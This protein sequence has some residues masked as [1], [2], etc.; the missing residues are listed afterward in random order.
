[1]RLLLTYSVWSMELIL[2]RFWLDFSL[3]SGCLQPLWAETFDSPP[4]G[5][6]IAEPFFP[7][8]PYFWHR[9]HF[10]HLWGPKAARSV[11]LQPTPLLPTYAKSRFWRVFWAQYWRIFCMEFGAFL[12]GWDGGGVSMYKELIRAAK[13]LFVNQIV[14]LTRKWARNGQNWLSHSKL[15]VHFFS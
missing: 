14:F 8:R 11:W 2:V 3:V 10:L 9:C 13:L 1:M 5:F 15:A 7:V 12:S 6:C 4:M